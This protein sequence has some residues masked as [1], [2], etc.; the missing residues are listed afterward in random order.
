MKT[1]DINKAVIRI[2]TVNRYIVRVNRFCR[3]T[4]GAFK[5]WPL[6]RMLWN[7]YTPNAIKWKIRYAKNIQPQE[8]DLHNEHKWI[9]S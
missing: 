8:F 5:I 1:I 7:H 9:K 3:A 6:R 2:K 4:N